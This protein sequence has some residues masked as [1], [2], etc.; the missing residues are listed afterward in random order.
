M[1]RKLLLTMLA[2]S[3]M[4]A[5]SYGV[6]EMY[7]GDIPDSHPLGT[8]WV[9]QDFSYRVAQMQYEEVC[10]EAE[11]SAKAPQMSAEEKALCEE[12]C[13]AEVGGGYVETE[14]L[15]DFVAYAYCTCSKCCDPQWNGLTYSETVPVEGRTVA[16]DPQ[17]I[18]LGTKLLLGY[19]DGSYRELIAEDTGAG[20]KGNALDVFISDHGRAS[21][22]GAQIVKVWKEKQ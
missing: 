20:I 5:P 4:T 13:E 17:I 22:H 14:F 15:G 3:I 19:E 8:E 12:A 16:V 1:K 21:E 11:K 6:T 18:P 2:L 7:R 9:V 10:E